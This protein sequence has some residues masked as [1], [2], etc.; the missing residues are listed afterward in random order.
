MTDILLAD[1]DTVLADLLSDYMVAEGFQVTHAVNGAEAVVQAQRKAFDLII[2]DVM[3]PEKNGF[4]ALR[5]IRTQQQT[6]VLMLTARG[7]DIDRIVGL[8][9]GAD[10]YMPKPCNPRELVARVRA[11]LRRTTPQVGERNALRIEGIVLTRADLRVTLDDVPLELTST[12]FDILATLMAAAGEV[13]S[14]NALCERALGRKLTAYDRSLDMHISNLRKK[15]GRRDDG[16]ERIKTVRG[17]G[18]LYILGAD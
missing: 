6:P 13:L 17:V 7:D 8:E 4:D 5:D 12:E 14:K 1:D 2:L 16:T 11:I 3:M 10:D 15:I 9:M 18:Y